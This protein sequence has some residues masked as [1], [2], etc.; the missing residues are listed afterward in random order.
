MNKRVVSFFAFLGMTVGAYVPIMLGWDATGLEGPSILGG[1]VG[2]L[3]AIAL[4][5]KLF[6][7]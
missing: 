3:L 4:V 6:K 7:P 5:V 1:L 2:G